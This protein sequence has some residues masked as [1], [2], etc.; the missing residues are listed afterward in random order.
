M[1]LIAPDSFKGTFTAAQVTEAIGRGLDRHDLVADPCPIADGGEG[2]LEALLM[3]GERRRV[4]V[5]DP[6]GRPVAAEFGLRGDVAIVETAAASGL[7]LVAPADRDPMAASTTG[8]GE[9]IVAAVAAGARTVYL[10]VGGSATTDGGAGAVA[11]VR[12]GGGLRGARLVVL[13]DVQTPFEQAARVFAGQKGADEEQIDQLT[14]RL[15]RQAVC[16]PR[17]PR[18]VPGTGAAGGLAGGLWANCGAELVSGASFVLD[19]VGFDRRCR[20]AAAV[21]TG[22][23]RLDEQSRAGKAVSEV[24]A[25]ARALRRHCYAIVGSTALDGG[26]AARMGIE[27]VLTASTLAEISQAADAVARALIGAG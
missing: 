21:V 23:G 9:L 12:A 26:K 18:G 3:G 14:E 15:R 5:T 24:G 4:S 13:C 27:Q 17:D 16:F 19:A 1:V 2:T 7:G 25:R 11:A 8:T 20:A 6:L 22:E 10:G